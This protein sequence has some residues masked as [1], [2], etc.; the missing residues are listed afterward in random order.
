MFAKGNTYFQ[1]APRKESCIPHGGENVAAIVKAMGLRVSFKNYVSTKGDGTET[2]Y[3]QVYRPGD[4]CFRKKL[5]KLSE[6]AVLGEQALQVKIAALF[7]E[8]RTYQVSKQ[9]SRENKNAREDKKGPRRTWRG[10]EGEDGI[11]EYGV[12]FRGD[13]VSIIATQ[14]GAED[15]EQGAS[16]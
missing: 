6:L 4:S 9:L 3:V 11:T 16:R 1:N 15:E 10:F 8:A 13:R 5:G 12:Y 7:R 14:E 2:Y